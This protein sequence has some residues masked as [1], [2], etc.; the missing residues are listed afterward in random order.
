LLHCLVALPGRIVAILATSVQ[1]AK[2][3]QFCILLQ[4]LSNIAADALSSKRAPF[5]EVNIVASSI[6]NALRLN[7]SNGGFVELVPLCDIV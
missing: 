1:H 3:I 7:K 5:L 4:R 6:R 2:L